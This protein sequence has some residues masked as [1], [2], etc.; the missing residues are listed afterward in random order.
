M[1][2]RDDKKVTREYGMPR[3]ITNCM[4]FKPTNYLFSNVFSLFRFFNEVNYD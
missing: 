2:C 3:K 4:L 1:Y